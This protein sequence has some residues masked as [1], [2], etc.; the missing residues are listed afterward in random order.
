MEEMASGFIQ[1]EKQLMS[2]FGNSLSTPNRKLVAAIA[3]NQPL[4]YPTDVF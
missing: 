2:L 3:P 4:L 1:S